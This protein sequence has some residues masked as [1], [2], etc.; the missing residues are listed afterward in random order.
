MPEPL[1]ED[2]IVDLVERPGRLV[3]RRQVYRWGDA[4]ATLLHWGALRVG[5]TR[6]C[7]AC[8]ACDDDH[9]VDL[10]FDSAT[11]AW[12]YYC[13]LAGRVTVAED[14]LVTYAFDRDWSRLAELL[15]IHRLEMTSLIDGVMWRRY[16]PIGYEVLDCRIGA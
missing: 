5:E 16:S 1:V 2:L 14:D 3:T 11:G 15:S 4:G 10:D 12:C 6:T 13:G 7:I 8:E 9:F